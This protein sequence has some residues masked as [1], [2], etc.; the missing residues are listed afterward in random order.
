MANE[1]AQSAAPEFQSRSLAS[2]EKTTNAMVSRFADPVR[3]FG[4]RALGFADQFLGRI[5][6]ARGAGVLHPLAD[7]PMHV[8]HVGGMVFARPWYQVEDTRTLMARARPFAATAAE[9][10]RAPAP[11]ASAP[12]AA[13]PIASVP[14][15]AQPVAPSLEPR[16]EGGEG[17]IS[18][19]AAAAPL[20]HEHVVVA[21]PDRKS[22]V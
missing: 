7:A 22:V 1:N 20:L 9:P 4:A 3:A 13:A 21:P 8:P 15:A 18:A 19:R 2:V 17:A 6:G 14:V 12:I 16:F 5:V 10:V 11:A